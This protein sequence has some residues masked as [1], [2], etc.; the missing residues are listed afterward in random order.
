[1]LKSATHRIRGNAIK[2]RLREIESI[3]ELTPELREES[4]TLQTELTDVEVREA[5]ALASEP[6]PETKTVAT[7]DG[8]DRERREIRS[9]TGLRDYLIA[10][11]SGA[12][13]SGAAAEFNASCGVSAGDHVPR[14]LFDAQ[15]RE[16]RAVTP[17][18]AVDAP[19]MPTVPFLFEA[20]VISTLG[21]EYPTVA[22]GL[23]QIPAIT[24]APPASVVAEGGAAPATAGA[25]TLT[26]RSPKRLTGQI[27]FSVEDLAVHPALESDLSISLQ[28]SLSSKLDEEGFNGG[29]GTALSGLFHQATNVNATG[30]TDD[31]S[32]ALTAFAALVDGRYSRGMA[33]LRGVV[34]PATFAHYM[35]LFKDSDTSLFEKLRA[36]MGSLVVSDRMPDVASGAQKGIVTLNA[37]GQPIRVYVWGSLQMIRNPYSG[38]GSGK[39]TVTAVQLVSDPFIPHGVNQ[40]VEV[41]R[42]LS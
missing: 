33:D 15:A 31:F 29:G 8:E 5:A 16:T 35:S 41:N 13:V 9:R 19:A 25:Y 14:E 11:C 40:A 24:T 3:E 21:L 42:D 23:Q 28:E 2:G 37:A 7:D 17:G 12:P 6:D 26:S 1:M 39:V 36:L 27:E 18:P 32:K 30:T 34:G 20:A 4:G 22:S 38:A 10:A